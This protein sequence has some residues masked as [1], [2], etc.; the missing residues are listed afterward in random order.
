[1]ARHEG[2]GLSFLDMLSCALGGMIL[3]FLIFVTFQHQGIQRPG[4]D[5][6]PPEISDALITSRSTGGENDPEKVAQL[7]RVTVHQANASLVRV[8]PEIRVSEA[9]D[10]N[11]LL[12]FVQD[13]GKA[14]GKKF[15]F[16]GN[17]RFFI[18]VEELHPGKRKLVSPVYTSLIGT[19]NLDSGW[20]IGGK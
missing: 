2:V 18:T 17:E 8:D 20:D 11:S 9:R 19:F 14:P 3:L 4:R 1:M 15:Q 10:G 6:P 12:V 13:P 5:R 16:Q 7:W